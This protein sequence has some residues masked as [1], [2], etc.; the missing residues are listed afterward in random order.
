M[1]YRKKGEV[2]VICWK[3]AR[4]VPIVTTSRE[5]ITEEH[6]ELRRK[7]R[8]GRVT[9]ERVTVQRPT[10]IGHYTR[11]MGGVHLVDQLMSYYSFVRRS[12]RWTH[13]VILY[14]IQLAIQNTY[15]L[16]YC[17][18]TDRKKLTH[19]Q[20]LEM[21]VN[22]L[23]AYSDTN[24]PSAGIPFQRA[25]SLPVN[26]RAG[27]YRVRGGAPHLVSPAADPAVASEAEE[28]WIGL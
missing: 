3:G 9:Y 27:H 18:T 11:H 24:W 10:I 20:F 7:K 2:F 14:L 23:L 4:V 6:R 15:C 19:I 26:E 5:P 22:S 13:K 25:A 16:Y 28:D 21:A 12:H 8:G 17:Y 1:R